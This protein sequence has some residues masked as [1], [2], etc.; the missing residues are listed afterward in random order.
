MLIKHNQAEIA[1]LQ[2][3]V[4]AKTKHD[5]ATAKIIEDKIYNMKN[6]IEAKKQQISEIRKVTTRLVLPLTIEK[7]HIKI[8]NAQM[9]TSRQKKLLLNQIQ[10]AFKQSTDPQMLC[11]V[12]ATNVSNDVGA[13]VTVTIYKSEQGAATMSEEYG[14]SAEVLGYTIEFSYN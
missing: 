14:F 4:D 9:R 7:S 6:Q 12:L 1:K 13:A 5:Q 8:L 11:Q 2:L 3:K 10:S